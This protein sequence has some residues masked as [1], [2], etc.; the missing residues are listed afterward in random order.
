MNLCASVSLWFLVLSLLV[1]EPA[2]P[3]RVVVGLTDDQQLLLSD[4][5][6]NGFIETRDGGGAVLLYR[7]KAFHGEM[8]VN[9]ID[10][11]DVDYKRGQP[12]PLVITMRN[13]QKLEVQADRRQFLTVS[14]KTENGTV[15]IKHPEPIT[16]PPDARTRKPNRARDLTIRYIEFVP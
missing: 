11:I 5:R 15:T 4:V 9:A 2:P 10:R 16:T 13:G 6:F 8:N 1:Q 12:F 14:G 7:Q 3:L